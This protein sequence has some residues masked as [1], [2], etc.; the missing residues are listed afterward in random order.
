MT[1]LLTLIR[2]RRMPSGPVTFY[3][4]DESSRRDAEALARLR[5]ASPD[6]RECRVTVEFDPAGSAALNR[7][8]RELVAAEKD[9]LAGL[10][11]EARVLLSE[12]YDGLLRSVCSLQDGEPVRDT[13]D[14]ISEPL[15][16]RYED[17]L[18]R[19]DAALAPVPVKET[20]A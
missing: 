8:V 9:R 17:I 12:E 16:Q 15:A 4:F 5:F 18:A 1:T 19:I 14:E 13:M 3:A 7:P 10:L 2:A 6:R 11:A 20:A